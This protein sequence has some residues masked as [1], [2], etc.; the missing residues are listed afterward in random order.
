VRPYS[1]K[2]LGSLLFWEKFSFSNATICFYHSLK[3]ISFCYDILI[4][5]KMLECLGTAGQ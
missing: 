3:E 1:S 4:F 2:E 5:R